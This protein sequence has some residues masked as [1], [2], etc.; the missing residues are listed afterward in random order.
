MQM[1]SPRFAWR[2]G[3]ALALVGG[4]VAGCGRHPRT[5][6]KAV[7]ANLGFALP[8]PDGHLIRLADYQGRPLVINFW[9]TYCG[10]CKAEI[11]ALNAL[12]DQYKQPPDFFFFDRW[13][14][15]RQLAILGVS[16]DD[17]ADDIRRFLGEQPMHY[18]VLMARGHDDFLEAFEA[19]DVM[20][21]SW[22]IR[23][24]GTVAAKSI[25]PQS[26]DWFEQQVK[27]LF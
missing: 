3:V 7:H 6:P 23:P 5:A 1:R 18:P 4:L 8:D 9:A 26:K 25:G 2:V 17:P 21:V 24:D 19:D 13:R 27:A 16:V 22:V 15:S 14:R 11:P 20:P 12:A 10:P